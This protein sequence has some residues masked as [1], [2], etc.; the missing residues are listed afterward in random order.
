M[1]LII[2]F[3]I[4]L[5]V[6]SCSDNN[7]SGKSEEVYN[8]QD[9]EKWIRYYF[10]ESKMIKYE[11]RFK[12]TTPVGIKRAYTANGLLWFDAHYND[13]GQLHGIYRSY[14]DN[15]PNGNFLEQE[16]QY[17]N[18]KAIG[19]WRFYRDNGQLSLWLHLDDSSNNIKYYARFD[20][21]GYLLKDSFGLFSCDTSLLK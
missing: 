15:Y 18:G 14:Y 13:K 6:I 10:P 4:L 11:G 16:G 7:G 8:T 5:F 2:K 20:E 19:F 1:K 3:I 21:R 9:N 12:D 17:Y